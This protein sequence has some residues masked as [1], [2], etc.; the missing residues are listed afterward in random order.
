MKDALQQDIVIGQ[1]YGYSSS[2]GSWITVVVGEAVKETPAGKCTLK[3]VS[4]RDFLYGQ[5]NHRSWAGKAPIVHIH[6]C[7]LFPVTLP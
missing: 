6:P 7:H 5:P 4:R 1:A 3:I 2:D